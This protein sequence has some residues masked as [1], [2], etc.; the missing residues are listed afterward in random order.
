MNLKYLKNANILKIPNLSCLF[1]GFAEIKTM[2]MDML[3]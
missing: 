1:L 3:R 2:K